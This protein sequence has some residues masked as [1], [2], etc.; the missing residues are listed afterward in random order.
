MDDTKKISPKYK[1]GDIVEYDDEF[2]FNPAYEVVSIGKVIG[3]HIHY[4]AGMFLGEDARGEIK[5][6]ISGSSLIQSEKYLRP[7]NK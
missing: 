6:T 7:Y 4:G 2:S 5:Y 3:I 1:I